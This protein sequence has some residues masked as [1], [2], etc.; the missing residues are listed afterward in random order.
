MRDKMREKN[1]EN[2]IVRV[3]TRLTRKAL[4]I[5]G[6]PTHP[7]HSFF[8]LLPSGRRLRSLQARTSRL[9]DSFV[10]QA[11]RKLNSLPSLPPLPSFTPRNT[12]LWHYT[13]PPPRP[14]QS[15]CAALEW[16]LPH[17]ALS[18]NYLLWQS[19]K[20][21]FFSCTTHICTV[22]VLFYLTGLHSICHVPYVTLSLFYYFFIVLQL[23]SFVYLYSLYVYM[24]KLYLSVFEC[25]LSVFN[26]NCMH[27]G[28]ESNAISILCMY[29]LYMWK[30][31]Q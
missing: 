20:R 22:F 6:D 5:A 27:Q 2:H 4:S 17:P 21:L 13:P 11:V 16:S 18:V 23:S 14:H 28:S 12:E 7:T 15:L 9:K 25:L 30:N 29:V 31:W 26:V 10:H 1:P 19:D 8:S 3:L 24:V